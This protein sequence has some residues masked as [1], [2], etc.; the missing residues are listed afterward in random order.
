M[1]RF[2]ASLLLVLGLAGSAVAGIS[3]SYI[4]YGVVTTPPVIDA[5]TFVNLGPFDI[6]LISESTNLGTGIGTLTTGF[7]FSTRDTLYFTNE[8]TMLGSPGFEFDTVTATGRHSASSFFNSGTVTGIDTP[9]APFIIVSA[10]AAVQVPFDSLPLPSQVIVHATNIANQGTMS[11][12]SVGLVQLTGQNVNLA[13]GALFA[14]SV[15]ESDIDD[16]T[17]EEST[18][19][20]EN[21]NIGFIVDPPE[22]YDLWWGA[23]NGETLFLPWSPP[24]QPVADIVGIR[25]YAFFGGLDLP[26]NPSQNFQPSVFIYSTDPFGTNLYYNIVFLNTNFVDQSG[27]TDTNIAAAVG[28]T[29]DFETDQIPIGD[30]NGAEAVVRFSEPVQDVISGQRVTNAIYFMDD[31]AAINPMTTNLNAQYTTG[32]SRPNTFQIATATPIDWLESFPGN[33]AYNQ[34]LIYA[35]GFYVNNKVTMTNSSYAAQIGRNPE[36]VDGSFNV[37]P[38]EF[39]F[40]VAAGLFDLPDMTNEPARLEVNAGYLNINN[41][42]FRAEGVVT[43]NGSNVVGNPYASDWG[44]VNTSL[45]ATNGLLVVSNI[46]P[47]TFTRLR[48]DLYAWGVNWMNTFTNTVTT[49]TI[50]YHV[51]I[52]DQNLGGSFRSSIR[53]LSLQATNVV[54]QDP[55]RVINNDVFDVINLVISNTVTLTQNAGNLAATNVPNLKNLRIGTNGSLTVD[56]V[57]NLGY[58]P[59][60]SQSTPAGRKYS[61]LSITNF[62]EMTGTSP[63]IQAQTIENDGS[64]TA[65][66]GGSMVINA[67]N[68]FLSQAGID[69]TVHSFTNTYIV[70]Q[71]NSFLADGN[72][73]ISADSIVASNSIIQAGLGGFGGLNLDVIS[74][75]TDNVP[76]TATTN[77]VLVNFWQTTDGF[78]LTTKP[79]GGHL[80]GTQ[81][82]SIVTGH[83][84]ANHVWAGID[85]GPTSN[86]FASNVVIGRLVLDRQ[87]NSAVMQFSGAGA[88]NAMYVDFLE[89]D[90]ASYTD[91]RQGLEIAPNLTIYFADCTADPIKLEQVYPGRM[92][93]VTN[94]TGPNSSAELSLPGGKNCYINAALLKSQDVIDCNGL[95]FAYDPNPPCP[96]CLADIALAVQGAE[97]GANLVLS[98]SGQ[99]TITPEPSA[100]KGL[101]MGATY[102]FA[103]VPDAGWLFGGW[104]GTYSSASST[105]TF[106]METNTPDVNLTANF[107]ANPFPSVAGAYNGLFLVTN[108][109]TADNSGFFTFTVNS[110]GAFS[111]KLQMGPNAYPYSGQFTAAGAASVAAKNGSTSLA[112]D[113][114]L[115]TS[116]QSGQVTGTVV[117]G[118]EWNA[119]LLGDRA[120]VWTSKNPAPQQGTYT[121]VLPGLGDEAA[122][123]AGDSYASVSVTAA[124]NVNLVGNLADGTAISQAV[125]V[126]QAGQWPFYSYAAGGQDTVLGWVAFATNDGGLSGNINWIK[127]EGAPHYYSGGFVLPQVLSGTRYTPPASHSSALS[128][129]NGVLILSGGNLAQDLTNSVASQNGLTYASADGSVILK[130]NSAKGGFTG[131]FVWPGTHRTT[132]IGGVLLQSDG[133]AEGFFLGT[134]Q[135]GAVLLQG[136]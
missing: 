82:K 36:N 98:V 46:F 129:T 75:L 17:G 72:I 62:G 68:L 89:L 99:G 112:V 91:Y 47:A 87:T 58:P 9:G 126:S 67:S 2:F 10:T 26:L 131:S 76:G 22:V 107:V 110:K 130:I 93:W 24:F 132:P 25:G 35:D 6:S 27:Q 135:S 74:N 80:Y 100:E 122:L 116:G 88:K 12:G 114:Q 133:I 96:A 52:L 71:T 61:I 3:P 15:S 29:F 81:I 78:S 20:I 21:G 79:A 83:N 53:N 16:L 103:A 101:V 8:N 121:L 45:T 41:S 95:P 19:F 59:S 31:G 48:G 13:N 106:T 64:I 73:A 11:A 105:L 1:K 102:T 97:T 40:D 55:L 111:G 94:F 109:V 66:N 119:S 70:G 120:P 125:P 23:T 85:Y 108:D 38:E 86:G 4:N 37:G 54:V 127:A 77:D 92:V 134:N 30:P 84:V 18:S 128:L 44:N 104:T 57:L 117:R 34:G 32:Y 113:L 39:D 60:L 5:T 63:L 69:V 118:E 28:F 49:N 56:S 14:G 123:P 90:D 50:H 33:N 51:L 7:P 124:G 42:R 65:G 136:N 115:D 43:L